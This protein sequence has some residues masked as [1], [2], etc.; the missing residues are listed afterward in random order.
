M[1]GLLNFDFNIEPRINSGLFCLSR[2]RKNI[3]LRISSPAHRAT[4]GHHTR[5]QAMTRSCDNLHPCRSTWASF[6]RSAG[7]YTSSPPRQASNGTRQLRECICSPADFHVRRSGISEKKRCAPTE[8]QIRRSREAT[9]TREN[10]ISSPPHR[11]THPSRQK[12]GHHCDR[13]IR[14]SRRKAGRESS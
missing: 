4:K 10:M 7:R 3:G 11:A 6:A 14:R 5:P 12:T 2:P 8:F 13:R 9:P 1:T